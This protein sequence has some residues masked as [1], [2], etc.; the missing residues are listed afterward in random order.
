MKKTF[1]TLLFCA[2]FALKHFLNTLGLSSC[3]SLRHDSTA[4]LG[5]RASCGLLGLRANS[6][7]LNVLD[8]LLGSLLSHSLLSFACSCLDWLL[9][10]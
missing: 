5:G 1:I 8:T 9:G 2:C 3:L 10:W 7:D 6:W 4:S